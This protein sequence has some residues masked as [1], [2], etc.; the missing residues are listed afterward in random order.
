M[1]DSLDIF[2][3]EE[4]TINFPV[5]V[6]P[7]LRHL[8]LHVPFLWTPRTDESSQTH[9]EIQRCTSEKESDLLQLIRSMTRIESLALIELTAYATFKFTSIGYAAHLIRSNGTKVPVPPI[10][11]A[12]AQLCEE[13]SIVLTCKVVSM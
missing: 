13:R 3:G 4:F 12:T 2:V 11:A 5:P 1:L 7:N 8:A 6:C 10:F 9:A